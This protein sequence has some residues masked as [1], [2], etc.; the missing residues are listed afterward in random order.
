MDA[1]IGIIAILVGLVSCFYGYPLF[2]ILLILA[3]LLGGYIFGQYLLQTGNPWLSL[4]VG[5]VS[6][7]IMAVLAYP[8][9][10]VSF[11]IAGALLGFAIL[12]EIGIAISASKGVTILL[13]MLGAVFFG[14]MFYHLKDFFVILTTA[15][16][17]AAEVAFGL[18]WI[19]PGLEFRPGEASWATVA[20]IML[21]GAAGSA[22]Q[23]G[24]FKG[25]RTY[26]E[27]PLAKKAE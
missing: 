16:K 18:C 21:L 6:A 19:I 26:S 3:G 12:G 11:T 24:M 20:I 23:Y 25:R 7:V 9:W 13:G 22:V 27:T 14:A 15:I 10:S 8:L 4:G 17:G 1:G 5:A 2:R